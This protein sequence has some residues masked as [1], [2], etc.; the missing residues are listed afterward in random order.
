[1]NN[2]KMHYSSNRAPLGLHFQTSW[3]QTSTNYDALSVSPV[4]NASKKKYTKLAFVL[5]YPVALDN[6]ID[7]TINSSTW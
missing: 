5:T 4:F 1:M 3:I 6:K 2:F 7:R